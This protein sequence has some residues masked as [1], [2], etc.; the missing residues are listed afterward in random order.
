MIQGKAGIDYGMGTSN[1][2]SET[3][4]H[5]GVIHQNNVLQAWCD[6]SKGYYGEPERDDRIPCEDCNGSGLLKE[7]EDG[8]EIE[9][10]FCD[11]TGTIE[12]DES[13]DD[14]QEPLCFIYE[15]KGYSAQSD[16][17]GDI[18]ITKSPYY[19]LCIYCSPCAPGAGYCMHEEKEGIKAYCFGH[20]WFEEG[21]APYTVYSVETG[22]VIET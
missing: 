14:M 17:M 19:C 6:S 20:N 10:S 13:F 15:E 11:G 5:Y 8:K 21:K 9:C 4:I 2:D 1:R 3:G 16:D 7:R 18:F 22:K 12:N